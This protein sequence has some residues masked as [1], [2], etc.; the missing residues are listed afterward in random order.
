MSFAAALAVVGTLP[1]TGLVLLVFAASISL[2]RSVGRHHYVV[3]A[4]QALPS[5]APCGPPPRS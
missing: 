5:P 2:A 4:S 3:D 1:V